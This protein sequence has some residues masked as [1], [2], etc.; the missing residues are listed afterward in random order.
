VRERADAIPVD[1]ERYLGLDALAS[2]LE[3]RRRVLHRKF[4][5]FWNELE[6]VG[7]RARLEESLGASA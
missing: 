7:F 1:D 5:E 4:V 3:A 2:Y 6:E